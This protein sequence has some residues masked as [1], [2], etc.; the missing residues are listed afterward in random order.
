[1]KDAR[2]P[3]QLKSSRW[4]DAHRTLPLRPTAR[5][6]APSGVPMAAR[7][8]PAR[9]MVSSLCWSAAI[10]TVLRHSVPRVCPVVVLLFC[11]LFV[12]GF[13]FV[14]F[15]LFLLTT[16]LQGRA[17]VFIPAPSRFPPSRS[18]WRLRC[19]S[20]LCL[21]SLSWHPVAD[22]CVVLYVTDVVWRSFDGV[23]RVLHSRL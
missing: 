5:R 11:C 2:F 14:M 15:V 9:L 4:R 10:R 1:M 16:G 21:R 12:F 13:F 8:Q 20:T 17:S 3:H 7:V 22:A 23:L 18:S 6:R 19:A